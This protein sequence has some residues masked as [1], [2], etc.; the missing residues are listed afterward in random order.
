[1][2][3]DKTHD[4]LEKEQHHKDEYSVSSDQFQQIKDPVQNF[5]CRYDSLLHFFSP[6][7][8]VMFAVV[9][10]RYIVLIS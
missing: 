6:S 8:H 2:F 10:Y 3:K 4:H 9:L 1:M 5:A 7:R